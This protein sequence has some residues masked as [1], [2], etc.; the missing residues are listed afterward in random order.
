VIVAAAAVVA[1][2]GIAAAIALPHGSPA[3]ATH[4]TSAHSGSGGGGGIDV[5]VVPTPVAGAVTPSSDG[6]SVVFTW[7]NPKPKSGDQFQ[8]TR[9]ATQSDPTQ[10]SSPTA[11]VTGVTPGDIVCI[12][13]VIVRSGRASPNPLKECTS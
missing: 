4:S 13:V 8:W 1:A 6:T 11:T 12:D 3:P 10:T 9:E 5:D 7:K 2:A